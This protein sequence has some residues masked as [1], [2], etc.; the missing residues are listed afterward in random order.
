MSI[1]WTKIG[2]KLSEKGEVREV[3]RTRVDA[4]WLCAFNTA[5]VGL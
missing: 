5:E 3:I 2:R 4:G 1:G